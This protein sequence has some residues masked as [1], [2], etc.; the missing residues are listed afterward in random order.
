M[1]NH[2]VMILGLL[3]GSLFFSPLLP[4]LDIV[5]HVSPESERDLRTLYGQQ[6][7]Q[8]ALE[9]TRD[10]FGDY[11]LRPAPP[12][13][14]TRLRQ[15]LQYNLY[16]NLLAID[17]FPRPEGSHDLD[18]VR[19]PVDLG[20]LGY[21][22]CFVSPKQQ[23]AV[24]RV[25][26]L[27][28]LQQFSHGQ[29]R[30]WQD[31][32]ILR[33]AGFKVQEVEGYERLFK[34]V[35]RGRVDLFCRGANELLTELDTHRDLGQLTVDQHL[36]LYYPFIHLFYSHKDNQ[37]ALRRVRAGLQLAW[38]DGSL[39][40]LWLKT[41]KPALD[42]AR[43]DQRLLFRLDNPLLQGLDFD[44]QPYLYDPLTQRFGPGE[45]ASGKQ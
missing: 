31:A 43:L 35:V 9:K 8:L 39:Q 44:Y 14:R 41:F 45:P 18:Y 37:H 23:Q 28:E 22:I 33:R 7:L 34:L 25:R 40:A 24:A 15:V 20:I 3:A 6:L 36:A 13:S 32:E 30:G 29:G 42:F 19:F 10:S 11:E 5:T 27:H 12:M 17:S 21:R 16:P 2:R 26:T 4:A 1:M 38:Q